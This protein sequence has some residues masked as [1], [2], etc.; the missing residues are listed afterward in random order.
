EKLA[1]VGMVML[2]TASVSI[3]AGALAGVALSCLIFIV[4][5]SRPI[6]RRVYRCDQAFSKR[7][8]AAEDAELLRQSGRRRAVLELE[9]VLFFSNAGGLAQGIKSLLA[10]CDMVLLDMRGLSDIHRSGARI[11]DHARA[12]TH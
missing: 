12:A 5:M 2:V 9:G 3:V 6:V 7:I 8:R 1:I 11:P 4:N 10:Y